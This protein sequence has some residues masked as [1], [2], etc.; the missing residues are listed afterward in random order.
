MNYT[1]KNVL[2]SRSLTSWVPI[3]RNEKLKYMFNDFN[4]FKIIGLT[5]T[6]WYLYNK[7][8]LEILDMD[9]CIQG[10]IGQWAHWAMGK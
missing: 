8:I 3:F 2:F 1:Y 7:V 9:S 6:D 10:H 5:I 4:V